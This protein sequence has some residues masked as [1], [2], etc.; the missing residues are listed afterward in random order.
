M[1][2]SYE[3]YSC[4]GANKPDVGIHRHIEAH[5]SYISIPLG[6]SIADQPYFGRITGKREV[7][8]R[9]V[10]RQFARN[11]PNVKPNAQEFGS[12]YAV[13]SNG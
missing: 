5:T 3:N 11:P 12:L 13:A 6:Q 10:S 7:I 1:T 9:K 8:P 2:S 4:A